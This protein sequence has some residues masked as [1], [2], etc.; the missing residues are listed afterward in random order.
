MD[1]YNLVFLGE[2]MRG[3]TVGFKLDGEGRQFAGR[4][5]ILIAA[6]LGKNVLNL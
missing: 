5:N 2:E 6:W 3:K 4:E 1:F